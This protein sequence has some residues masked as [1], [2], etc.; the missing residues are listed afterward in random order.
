[1]N[2][3]D[4]ALEI[5]TVRCYR[6][7]ELPQNNFFFIILIFSQLISKFQISRILFRPINRA[8]VIVRAASR[9]PK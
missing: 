8:E 1:M 2:L 4:Q 5:G 9:K 3:N 6:I 7:Y